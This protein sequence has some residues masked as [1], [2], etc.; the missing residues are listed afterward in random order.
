MLATDGGR[1]E[2]GLAS[3]WRLWPVALVGLWLVLVFG[4]FLGMG[5]IPLWAMG[6]SAWAWL[7]VGSGHLLG[8]LVGE[9]AILLQ[10]LW[11]GTTSAGCA[12]CQRARLL[13]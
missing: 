8:T 13:S 11:L 3:L 9:L 5:A 7:G 6:L 1:V 4:L 2:F 12:L 10:L